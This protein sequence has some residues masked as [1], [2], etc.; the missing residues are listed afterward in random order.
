MRRTATLTL[1][2]LL[3]V[4]ACG[5]DDD[6]AADE[7]SPATDGTTFES[8]SDSGPPAS[9][10]ADGGT[11]AEQYDDTDP[12][13]STE[14]ASSDPGDATSS[15][16][17]GSTV[18][19][20]ASDGDGSPADADKP[21]VDLP[22]EPPTELVVTVLEDGTGEPSVSGDTLIVDY[23]GVRSEDG[24][25]FD[26]SYERDPFPITLGSTNVIAG[27]QEGLVGVRQ[28]ERVQLDIPSELAYGD[29]ERS[30]VIGPN[31]DLTF[32][33]D[34]HSVFKPAGP[35]DAPTEPGV[36]LSEDA[37][38]TTFEDLVEGEGDV[39]EVGDTALLRYVNFRGDNGVALETNWSDDPLQIPYDE[40]L[41]PGLFEGM[42]GMK[43][44][45]RRAITIPPDD[46]FGPDGNPQGG[47]PRDTD[48]IFVVELLG[49]Y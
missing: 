2:A 45:G 41:L 12:A 44:G 38:D 48:M 9:M 16:P 7:A 47:L 46:G 6:P 19:D 3:V 22:D 35:D 49:A 31:T 11:A 8:G 1:A 37:L 27:W 14:P 4:T 34:V 5:S 17:A 18:D 21:E 26:S 43:V 30:E 32:V 15:L 33:I 36:A 23:V 20:P 40:G 25:E 24:V 28:G 42:E 29:Q 10:T 13:S 39:L